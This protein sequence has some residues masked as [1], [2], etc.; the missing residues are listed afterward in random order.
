MGIPQCGIKMI[1]TPIF[2]MFLILLLG[3]CWETSW[4]LWEPI[5]KLKEFYVSTMGTF[6]EFGGN[7]FYHKNY[8]K[9]NFGIITKNKPN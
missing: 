7:S 1:F 9:I 2:F 3:T 6:W 5:E 8:P 4:K